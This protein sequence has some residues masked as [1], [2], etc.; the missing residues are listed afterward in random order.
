[1]A[2]ILIVDDEAN[3][4]KPLAALLEYEGYHIIQASDGLEGLKALREGHPDLILLDMSMPGVDG[5]TMLQAIR[6]RPDSAQLPVLLVTGEHNPQ[7]LCLAAKL[8]VQEYIFK[9]D[10][11]FSRMLELIKRHLGEHHVP[12][13]RGRKPKNRPDGTPPVM[14]PEDHFANTSRFLHLQLQHEGADIEA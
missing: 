4:R 14:K 9:G 13:R 5:V 3:C 11:P 2:T 7:M 12:K 1:M 8:G 10:T 6:R